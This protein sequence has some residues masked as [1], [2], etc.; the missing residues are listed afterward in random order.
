M[1]HFDYL[2]SNVLHLVDCIV[3]DNKVEAGWVYLDGGAASIESLTDGEVSI[4]IKIHPKIQSIRNQTEFFLA[5][6][7]IEFY[8]C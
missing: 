3:T 6:E 5:T 4:Q 8:R 1:M 2:A 7:P